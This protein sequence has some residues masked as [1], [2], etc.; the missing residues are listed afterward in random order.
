[1]ELRHLRYFQALA[2]ELNF[3]RAADRVHIVQSALSKQIAGLEQELGVSLFRRTSRGVELTDAGRA[4]KERI[5]GIL[6]SLDAAL[7]TTRLTASGELGR[8]QVGFIAAA[9]WGV[10]PAILLEHRRRHPKVVFGLHELPMAGEHLDPLLDGS[11]DVAFVRPIARFRTLAFETLAREQL[12]AVLPA[13]HALARH[14]VVELA[15]LADERFVLMPRTSYPEAHDLYE[16][17]CRD[18]GFTPTIMDQGDSPNALYMV[19]I[20]FGV[21]LAPASIEAAGFPG[22]AVR[23]LARPTPD[24]ELAITYRKQ[25]RS[26]AVIALVETARDVAGTAT[27]P[28]LAGSP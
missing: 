14:D 3:S 16:Q 11:L 8:L 12:V 5:D 19:A 21:A 9:M 20:G 24:I 4:L 23:P 28:L 25:N 2:D 26:E 22:V 18:V 17:A 1:M 15:E 13:S 7:D 27:G 6:P 10:L